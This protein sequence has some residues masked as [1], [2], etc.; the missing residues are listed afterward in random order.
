MR[1][2][3]MIAEALAHTHAPNGE[4]YWLVKSEGYSMKN[5]RCKCGVEMVQETAPLGARYNW[6][7]WRVTE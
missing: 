4:V 1:V 5:S 2:D 7:N 3:E 6:E